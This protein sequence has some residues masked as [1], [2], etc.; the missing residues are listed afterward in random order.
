[1]FTRINV[2]LVSDPKCTKPLALTPDRQDFRYYDKDGFE[3]CQ[4]ELRYYELEG[5]PIH[6][7]ILNHHLWQEE[8]LTIDH[9]R[10]MLDHAMI[11]HR[12]DFQDGA[13]EQL[14]VI[15]RTIP[16]ADLLLRTKQQWG[17]D[18]DMDYV[19][20]DGEMFE[21]LH[22]ECDFNDFNEFRDKLYEFED[23]INRM[24]FEDSA[25]RIWRARDEWRHLK[26]F[27]QNDWKAKYLLGWEKSEY[28]EK[29]V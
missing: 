12:C 23:R 10:L 9:P 3:L 15:K 21:V 5:H 19:R 29:A 4:A 14:E 27:T 20:E 24:D 25:R 11:L 7:P 16:Q 17:F 28:T 1:M 13:R 22:V 2:P 26:G 8:W 6:Q 18:F